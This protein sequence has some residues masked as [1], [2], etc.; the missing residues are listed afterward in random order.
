MRL[1]EGKSELPGAF[2]L[3]KKNY[4]TL[5]LQRYLTTLCE[6][7]ATPSPPSTRAL[8]LRAE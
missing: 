7:R 8:Y 2:H 5:S 6:G 3:G 4:E 1:H